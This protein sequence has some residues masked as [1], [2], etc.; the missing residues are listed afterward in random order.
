MSRL[1]RLGNTLRKRDAYLILAIFNCFWVMVVSI[2]LM[3]REGTVNDIIVTAWFTLWAVELYA[4]AS[5]KKSERIKQNDNER[6]IDGD[7]EESD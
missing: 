3:F 4:L 5:I 7:S 1:E 2:I 6:E